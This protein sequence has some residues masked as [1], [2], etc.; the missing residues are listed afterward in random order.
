M[1]LALAA[2]MLVVAGCGQTT[3]S[4][5]DASGSTGAGSAGYGTTVYKRVPATLLRLPL[6]NQS[7]KRVSLGSWPGRTVLLVP[8]LSLCQD[9]CPMTT[10]NLLQVSQTL[11]ADHAGAKVEIVELT[12]DPQ[13]DTPA[14]LAAYAKLTG[15]DWQLVTET[16]SELRALSKFFG[17]IYQRVPEERPAGI[18]W[19]TGKRLTYDVDHSDNY[20]VLDPTG[21]ERVIQDA[22]PDFKGRLNP[23]LYRFLSAL[24]RAHL[25]HVP[26][27][28]WTPKDALQALAVSVGKPF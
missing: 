4:S 12:V 21:A 6:T 17:F 2:A 20:F 3:S 1:P 25:S 24:G 28:D 23:K 14:R 18:D 11:R 13:R 16:P 7:G 22:A 15:A 27:P 19:W 26:Q 10:G 8:F 5:S 9:I